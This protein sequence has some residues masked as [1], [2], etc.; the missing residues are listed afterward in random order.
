MK[1]TIKEICASCQH[2]E[3]DNEGTRICT[4]MQLKVPQ[5]FHCRL[6]TLAE[7]LRRLKMKS[8]K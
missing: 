6:W 7:G 8:E 2:K 5:R 3:I 4:K 1:V